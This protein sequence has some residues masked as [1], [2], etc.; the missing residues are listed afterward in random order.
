[1]P[2]QM[3]VAVYNSAGELVRMLYQGAASAQPTQLHWQGGAGQPLSLDLPGP[4]AD[5]STGL[6]WNG[7][8][9]AG[10]T[11]RSGSYLLKVETQDPFGAVQTLQATVQM[12]ATGAPPQLA[13]YNSAGELVRHWDL[14]ALGLDAV[15]LGHVSAAQLELK[16]PQGT[17]TTLA[18]DG[19]N[20]AGQPLNGGVYSLVLRQ[21]DP[22]K[23]T[24]V[25]RSITIIPADGPDPLASLE[26]EQNPVPAGQHTAVF[27]YSPRPGV[28]LQ[29]A[30]YSLA[31]ERVAVADASTPGRLRVSLDGAASGVYMLVAEASGGGQRQT[32][33]VLKLGLVR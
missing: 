29:A 20:D 11:V 5:G 31:G 30:L 7:L 22:G 15:D 33:R 3:T 18:W 19:L 14:Q 32:R 25:V 4:L 8:N 6:V 17:A 1:M 27:R 28:R 10:Q 9:A 16:G 2:F 13:L 21:S 12:L 24:S 23:P 26:P